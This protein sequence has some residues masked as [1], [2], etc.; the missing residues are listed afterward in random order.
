MAE[1]LATNPSRPIR[2]L[3]LLKRELVV[4]TL[5][6]ATLALLAWQ[7]WGMERTVILDAKTSRMR[8]L[9]IDDH[10]EG[11]TS[12]CKTGSDSAGWWLHY[13]VHKGPNWVFCGINLGFTE[14]DSLAGRDLS[15]FDTLVVNMIH[16]RGPNQRLQV[17]IK[18][19]DPRLLSEAGIN[20]M[21]YHDMILVPGDSGASRT[22]MP[23]DNFV[24]PPWWAGRYQV[25]ARNL[26]PNRRDVREIEFATS[27]D[28][29]VL[30]TGSVGI[31]SLELHGKWIRQ[32]KL[33]KILLV[34]WLA[35]IT[36]GLVARLFRAFKDIRDLQGQTT[37][38]KDLS[39][40]DPLTLLHNRR[41][42]ENRL[43]G[44]SQGSAE[45]GVWR[46]GLLMLDLDHFK[47]VNDTL[48]HDA[49]DQILRLLA[50]ILQEEMRPTNLAARWGGEEFILLLPGIPPERLAPAAERVRA[51]IESDLH[52]SG[53]SFTVS[54]GAALGNLDDFDDL[55]KR[56]DDAL[57]RAK[58]AGRN[59]VE[60]A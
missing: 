54:I 19:N 26:D 22:S 9:T 43:A 13:D 42:L 25:P 11:G 41:G 14:G 21:K 29:L 36:G 49:G 15:G 57:Y 23:L 1:S 46:T 52:Y 53:M 32:D 28:K 6:G 18:A 48:G 45:P 24:I 39:E 5:I 51:R 30:G 33:I 16:L 58:E 37:R 47:S 27:A 4:L 56:A 40:R 55:V 8:I 31:R 34:M 20:S 10:G 38:L 50:G 60:L 2:W 3:A 35:Y 7:N 59:R 12:V 44:L 17:Q